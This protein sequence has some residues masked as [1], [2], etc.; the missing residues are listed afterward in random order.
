MNV[1]QQCAEVAK[2]SGILACIRNS[3]V[4]STRDVVIPL[5]SGISEAKPQ[6]LCSVLGPL[7][8]DIESW[9]VS[10]GRATEWIKVWNKSLLRCI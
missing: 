10:K 2:A 5:Y 9:R 3:D 8:Q 6:L 1:S 4:S 7:L